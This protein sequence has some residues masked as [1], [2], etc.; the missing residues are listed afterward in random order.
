MPAGSLSVSGKQREDGGRG[1]LMSS[2]VF[3][4]HVCRGCLGRDAKWVEE[5][6]FWAQWFSI[7]PGVIPLKILISFGVGVVQASKIFNA[8]LVILM[9]IQ[10]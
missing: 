1:T 3:L 7:P 5:R 8:T 9:C 6:A 10:D 2:L 4:D